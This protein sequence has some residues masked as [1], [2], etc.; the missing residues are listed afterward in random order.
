[1][2]LLVI[3]GPKYLTLF[4]ASAVVPFCTT[5]CS[6]HLLD[7]LFSLA[8]VETRSSTKLLGPTDSLW[9]ATR[10][11]TARRV[12]EIK[13]DQIKEGV[14]L[15]LTSLPRRTRKNS[16]ALMLSFK[17]FSRRTH[18]DTAFGQ[19]SKS[20]FCVTTKRRMAVVLRFGTRSIFLL[21]P[22]TNGTHNGNR[23]PREAE[24]GR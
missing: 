12:K 22:S 11:M 9:T 5:T 20:C 2:V 16:F 10:P 18:V 7:D 1:M 13:G 3:D 19:Q 17:G 24:S 14:C 23:G 21:D 15:E 6:H 4:L 8:F